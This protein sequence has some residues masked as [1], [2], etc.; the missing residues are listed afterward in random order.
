MQFALYQP[1]IR[2]ART[3][4]QTVLDSSRHD[5]SPVGIATKVQAGIVLSS[6]ESHLLRQ[7]P[8]GTHARNAEGWARLLR[9]VGAERLQAEARSRSLHCLEA[10]GELGKALEGY[11]QVIDDLEYRPELADI[12]MHALSRIVAVATALSDREAAAVAIDESDALRSDVDDLDVI[13]RNWLCQSYYLTTGFDPE[14]ANE[15]LDLIAD[16]PLRDRRIAICA[17]LARTAVY[18]LREEMDVGDACLDISCGA[19]KRAGLLRTAIRGAA[20]VERFRPQPRV[21]SH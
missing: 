4:A 10:D 1:D 3:T 17:E 11:R 7:E 16:L 6:A 21:P 20:I 5:G 18:Y 15:V 13:A 12:R 19:A 2:Q 8:A 9:G 14:A